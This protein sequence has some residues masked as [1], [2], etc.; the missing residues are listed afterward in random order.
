M[1]TPWALALFFTLAP[2]Q[3]MPESPSRLRADSEM[4][5]V[6][7]SVFDPKDQFLPTLRGENFRVYDNGVEQ[8]VASLTLEDSPV[9][10]AIL[11]DASRS[12]ESVLPYAQDSVSRFLSGC[13]PED[14]FSLVTVRNRPEIALSRSR[15]KREVL[16]AV[17]TAP[18]E[19][20][21]A[22]LDGVYLALD[23]LR[24]SSYARKL[25]LV[26]SDGK[27]NNSRYTEGQIR[28]LLRETDVVVYTVGVR[29]WP[30]SYG[31]VLLAGMAENSGGRY[32]KADRVKE[33]PRILGNLNL[34]YQYVLGYCPTGV[35][36]DGKYHKLGL[37][38][39]TGSFRARAFWRPGYYAQLASSR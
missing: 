31:D 32:L 13:N 2:M 25:L 33:L 1:R 30:E 17:K 8:R 34:R 20:A 3:L 4:V 18:A 24:H 21:T 12:M 28:S 38:L 11:F 36:R 26:V 29:V 10:I 7:A 35:S 16:R 39:T 15:D 5:L 37:R 9:S 22:L 6:R 14:E 19:G 27:D 23:H